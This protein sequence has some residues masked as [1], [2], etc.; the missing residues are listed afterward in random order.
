[1]NYYIGLNEND[2]KNNTLIKNTYRG[3]DIISGGVNAT[4]EIAATEQFSVSIFGGYEHYDSKIKKSD[5]VK[6]NK[7]IYAGI[8]IRYSF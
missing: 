5:L 7:Q 8:G 4:I 1:M 3:E 2:V 6:E